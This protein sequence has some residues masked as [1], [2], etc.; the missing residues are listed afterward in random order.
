MLKNLQARWHQLV[1]LRSRRHAE[2]PTAIH[3]LEG[4]P[5]HQRPVVVIIQQDTW[6]R[7]GVISIW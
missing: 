6:I 2:A 4:I 7:L 3:C 1:P 5:R